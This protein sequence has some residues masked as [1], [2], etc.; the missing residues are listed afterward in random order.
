[1]A[2]TLNGSTGLSGIVGSAGTPALQ[3]GDTNT[4][5]YF[6]T[7]ILGLST[8]G[9]TRLYIDSNGRVFI[10]RVAQ[11]ASSSERLSVN[12]MTSIQYNSTSAAGLYI[13]NEE[14]TADGT[15][16]PFIYLHDGSGIR[17]GLGVQR[18]TGITALNGQFG[19]SLRTGASGVAG[20]Q[21]ILINSTGEVLI[22]GRTAKPNDINELVVTGTSPADSYD[23][24]LYLEGSETTGAAN[25]GGALAFGGHDNTA[26]RNWGNIYGLKENG[27]GGNTASYMS[28]HT[29]A[30]GG[31]PEERLRITSTGKTVIGHT[32]VSGWQNS[33]QLQ[34]IT[35]SSVGGITT[36]RYNNDYGGYGLTLARSKNNTIGAHGQ[37]TSGQDIGHIQFVGSDG[38]AFRTLGD[39]TCSADGNVTSTSAE[40]KIIFK[41]SKSASVTPTQAMTIKANHNVEI[42][43][44]NIVFESSSNG[45]DFSASEGG[46]GTSNESSL[47][48]DYEE[49]TF[50]LNESTISVSNY[51]TRYVKIG[52]MVY[53]TGRVAFGSSSDTGIVN[54]TGIPFAPN[55]D[56]N[57]SAQAG[58]IGE[59]SLGSTPLAICLETSSSHLRLRVDNITALNR[60]QVSG[61]SIRFNLWYLAAA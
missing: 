24:Q 50:S 19:V 2:L 51:G 10:N 32:A 27:T 36:C 60:S 23:S 9:N 6:G 59:S 13:F 43:D 22:G 21:R 55:T 29:R 20:T 5:Y 54:M 41:T 39:I 44:G 58:Y 49:G 25:T 15:T 53:L 40:G 8:G 61:D 12:G 35:D 46:T 26:F 42:H 52:K 1:M 37:V 47:L 57:N 28:F 18:S 16:Q 56:I 4:G 14:T 3:G 11:H 34:V 38:S 7:D 30:D 33:T 17:A 48:A 45:I 31:N